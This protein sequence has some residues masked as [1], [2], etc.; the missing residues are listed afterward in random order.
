MRATTRLLST[1]AFIVGLVSVAAC[2]GS[3][4]TQAPTAT[5]P[6][7]AATAPGG[8]VLPSFE[9]PVLPSGLSLPS[10]GSLGNAP[11]ASS[12]VTADMAAS[13][14]GA[15]AQQV[16]MPVTGIASIVAYTTAAGDTLTVL[17]EK[18]PGGVPAAAMQAAMRMAGSNGD[19]QAV[20]GIGDVAGK[21]VDAN[22]ATIAFAKGD[23]IVVLAAHSDTAAGSELEPKLES[24]ARQ[25]TGK[26]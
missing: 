19:L 16:S 1:G 22:E 26:L 9:I 12:I 24:L 14:L 4:A 18:V 17:V 5:P 21:V 3:A 2:G 11:D 15:T 7:V 25:V 10:A 23:F 20:G 6:Q 13:L 8:A